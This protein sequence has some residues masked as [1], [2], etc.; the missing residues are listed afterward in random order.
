[1]FK[2]QPDHSKILADKANFCGLGKNQAEVE[3]C[4]NSVDN[5]NRDIISYAQTL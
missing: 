5:E 1:M 4:T 2:V 3:R